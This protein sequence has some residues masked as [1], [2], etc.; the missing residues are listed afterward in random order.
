MKKYCENYSG[1]DEALPLDNCGGGVGGVCLAT[2]FLPQKKEG[3]VVQEGRI[4]GWYPPVVVSF[5]ESKLNH[6]SQLNQTE[7]LLIHLGAFQRGWHNERIII[8]IC[9]FMH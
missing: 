1:S 6:F 3:G 7:L 4:G 9:T 8:G 5:T 2:Y